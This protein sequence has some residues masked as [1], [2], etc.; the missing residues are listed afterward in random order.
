MQERDDPPPPYFGDY[1]DGSYWSAVPS[2]EERDV[3]EDYTVEGTD[4][5]LM[6]DEGGGPLWGIEGLLPDDPTWLRRALGLSEGL[7]ADLIAWRDDMNDFNW[8]LQGRSR[9]H[10]DWLA[11]QKIMDQRAGGLVE[12]LQAELE[13]RFE[14][15]YR[16]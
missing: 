16:A 8:A 15:R 12:R 4:L 9:S 1:P 13:N 6:W 11:E 7:I 5:R 10:E 14:V 3:E 2:G